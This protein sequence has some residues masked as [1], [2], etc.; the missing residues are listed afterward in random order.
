[1]EAI[2]PQL[3]PIVGSAGVCDWEN[4]DAIR[5]KRIF[6]AIAPENPPRCI[7][8][9]NTQAELASVIACAH[10]NKWRVLPCGSGSK[11]GWG[12]LAEGVQVVVSTERLKQVIEHA[13][14]D[15]T[16]TV[17]AGT[18][19]AD[20]Q[21]TLAR[22]GQFLALDPSAPESAT[23]GG[24][25]ATSDTGSL[26]QRYNGVR[27]QLLGITFVRADGQIAKAG[28]RVVKNVAGYDLMKLFTGSYGTLGIITSVT[29]RVYPLPEA[30][31]TVVLTGEADAIAQ[32]STT[33]RAS[34]LTPYSADLL[35]TRLVASLNIGQGLG[36]STRFASMTESVKEQSTRLMEVGQ[37]LGLQGELYCA[38]DEAD[39]WQKLRSQMW[40]ST[41]KPVIICKI[42]VIP[43]ASVAILSQL[44]SVAPQGGFGR[45]H[46]SSGLGLLRLDTC[47][48]MLETVLK[49]RSLLVA[50]GG[51]LSVLEA[52]IA[53]KQELDV[54][55]YTG[56]ALDVMR[57]IK[58][59]FDPDNILS[60]CRFVG[61]I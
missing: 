34:A 28:G 42:G 52:P 61:G 53:L 60:P 31:G 26:R 58:Q 11:L 40:A 23:M 6:Q 4:I 56:N 59:Q 8:Y 3:E 47:A 7:V 12:R 25:V 17:E 24:I 37:Q 20:L 41:T 48:G 50:E 36:L 21:D 30:S 18:K 2:A 14:G 55:G 39:L 1:M 13:V 32:A 22:S 46:S 49:M 54:W 45:I 10:R 9:P 15:L 29:F 57:R 38:G 5:Q 35:S 51:F 44:D 33:M 27:D 16:V 19:F 43:S